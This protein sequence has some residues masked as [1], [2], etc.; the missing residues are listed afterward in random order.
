MIEV[1][2]EGGYEAVSVRRVSRLAGVSTGTFYDHFEGK[3][4]CF[5]RT[6]ELVVQR[7][8]GKIVAAQS[9]EPN[10]QERM[11]CAFDAFACEIEAKPQAARLALVEALAAGPAALEGMRC[12]ES[13]FE[14][15]IAESFSRDP[16][17]ARMPSL[18]IKGIVAG[19]GSVA[20]G[21]LL[22]GREQDLPV[23][24]GEL[25][26]WA[27]SFGKKA[28]VELGELDRRSA[29]VSA[30]AEFDIAATSRGV[31]KCAP[32]DDRDLI[33]SA[34][35]KLAVAVDYSQLTVPRIR[36]AA[37]VPRRSFDTQFEGVEDCFLATVELHTGRALANA[38][39]YALTAESWAGGVY[40]GVTALCLDAA[41]DPILARLAF[42]DASVGPSGMRRREAAAASI[43]DRFRASAPDN[44]LGLTTTSAEASIGAIWGVVNHY[45]KCGRAQQLPLIA[46]VLSFLALA[47]VIGG[48][49]ALD[50]IRKEQLDA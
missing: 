25:L 34:V 17:G 3:E 19:V 6:Y 29:S 22:A 39:R 24:S 47:P 7:A 38:A 43:A 42:G 40:R 27:L 50:A 16:D 31:E 33:L 13:L 35:A 37:G 44:A 49:A 45:I 8:A 15:M 11:R 41:C 12:T 23:L 14:A 10:W 36:V 1:V 4:E 21:R 32:G 18:L 2:G 28:A 46:T 5:L 9:G 26:R 48:P 30:A 20:R